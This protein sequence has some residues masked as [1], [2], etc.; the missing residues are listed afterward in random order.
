M[1]NEIYGLVLAG[2]RSERMGRDKAQLAYGGRT[3]LAR[4]LDLVKP[5]CAKL[6]VSLREGQEVP[7]EAVASGA[8]PLHD[9][10]GE[11][12]PL[13]GIL[14]AFDR[15]H[16]KSWLVVAVDMPFL[17][18]QTLDCLLA[19]RK[20]DEPITAFRSDHDSLPEPLCAV[21]EPSSRKILIEF[22][23]ERGIT[24]PRKI[25]I[26]SDTHLLDLPNP[27]ALD[28][29]NTPS[30]HAEALQRLSSKK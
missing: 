9:H 2:G 21:Y 8:E 12:G 3:Q 30:E 22:F 18:R 1:G 20:P 10:F 29:I 16:D 24:C 5:R 17:D 15:H 26:G 14:T 23:R 7:A 25:M 19:S 27:R 11:I 6:F 13:G 4:T 28:N